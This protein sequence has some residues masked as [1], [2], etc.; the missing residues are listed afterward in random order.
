M[1]TMVESGLPKYDYTSWIALT[2]PGNLPQDIVKRLHA[3][4]LETLKL[5]EVREGFAAQ[6]IE[7]VGSTP[8]EA[9]RMF[10]TDIVKKAEIVKK[11]GAKVD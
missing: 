5:K 4:A 7:I 3:A 11:S 6:G 1:P 9:R 2:A 10:E 8:E